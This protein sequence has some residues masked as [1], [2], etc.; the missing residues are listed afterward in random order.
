MLKEEELYP[1][2]E[3]NIKDKEAKAGKEQFNAFIRYVYLRNIDKRWIDHLD[4]LEELKESAGLM[5]YAQKNPLVEY[6]NTASDAF[7]E[8]ITLISDSVV[9][10]VVSV[11]IMSE[12]ERRERTLNAQ[13]KSFRSAD[14]QATRRAESENTTI[15]RTSPKIGRNDPCPCGS[16]K[17]YKNCCGK[18]A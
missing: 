3:K 9:K 1:H 16:G 10:T 12:R 5:S 18:N 8:M 7:D 2:L 17:K 13:H 11:K 15:R 6:K 4:N 14:T